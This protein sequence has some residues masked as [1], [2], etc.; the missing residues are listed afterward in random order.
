VLTSAFV[1]GAV[2]L[3]P[4][5]ANRRDVLN[6]PVLLLNRHFAP[7]RLAALR[8]AIVLLYGGA[9]HAV[10]DDGEA[11][12]FEAWLRQPVRANDDRLPIV[13]GDVRVPRVMHLLRKLKD[14]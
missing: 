8:R 4:R 14:G 9:A 6:I 5:R 3:H 7:V 10:D 2:S 12:D 13:G 1:S 11:Y